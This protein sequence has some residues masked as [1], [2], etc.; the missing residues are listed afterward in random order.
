[1]SLFGATFGQVEEDFPAPES[2]P[3]GGDGSP[4]PTQTHVEKWMVRGGAMLESVVRARGSS[5]DEV[6]E[7]DLETLAGAVV[8]YATAKAL[9]K[10]R[11]WEQGREYMSEFNR[12]LEF[13]RD[14]P[15]DL[16]SGTV[17]STIYRSPN[18][19]TR[20]PNRWLDDRGSKW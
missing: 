8:A 11:R 6:S 4:G 10:M 13:W 2:N 20:P 9:F 19:T 15:M 1:M 3:F 12:V 18:S 7:A 17:T 14:R 16:E 5:P